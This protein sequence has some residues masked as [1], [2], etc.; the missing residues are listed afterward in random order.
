MMANGSYIPPPE[1]EGGWRRIH[2][3][4]DLARLAGVSA[5][6]LAAVEDS[7]Q[8]MHAGLLWSVVVVLKGYVVLEAHAPVVLDSTRFD[9]WSGSKS[10]TA[11]AWGILLDELSRSGTENAL[12]LDDPIYHLIPGGDPLTDPLKANITLRHLL[13]MCSG[14]PGDK[15][16]INNTPTAPT[17]GAFE[18]ALG[19]NPNRRG[20]WAAKLSSAPGTDW[21]YSDAAY[22]HLSL[23]FRNVAGRELADYMQDHVFSPIGIEQVSWDAQGGGAFAGPHTTAQ[24][25]V[26][27]SGRELARFG[28]LMLRGGSWGDQQPVPKAW[29]DESTKPS[30][31]HNTEYGLGWWV[32]RDGTTWPS[33][34]RDTFALAGMLSNRCY[35]V[36]SLDLVIARVGNGPQS[37]NDRELLEGVFGSLETNAGT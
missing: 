33:A 3:D 35:V 26:H 6:R 10:F 7:Q 28:Y 34:P 17:V 19:R 5:S 8:R 30:Q 18:H 4:A 12:T 15:Y 11:T 22:A 2:D 14:I 9:I 27:I 13:S 29:I 32:N 25:G 1:S 23:L 16:G 36:P 24:T 20:N 21:D 37:W 31:P